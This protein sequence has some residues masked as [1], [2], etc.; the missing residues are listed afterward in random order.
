MTRL[1]FFLERNRMRIQTVLLYV[2]LIPFLRP[3][4]FDEVWGWY[5]T[6]FTLWLYGAMV[7]ILCWAVYDVFHNGLRYKACTY[8]MAAYY[9]LFVLITLI[10]QKGINEGLQK[11]FAAPALYVFC[12]LSLKTDPRKFLTAM[13]NII[14]VLFALSVTVLCPFV[15]NYL[16]NVYHVNFL[17]HVQVAA[18]YCL[19]AC[20]AAYL[21]AK[22]DPRM[23]QRC[24]VLVCLGLVQTLWAGTAAGLLAILVLVGGMLLRGHPRL[25]K[26]TLLN[27]MFFYGCYVLINACVFLFS[28][29]GLD[30]ALGINLS[31]SGRTEIWRESF[32][33]IAQH[34]FLG[35][36]AY[37]AEI[38]T[39][40]NTGMNYAHNE[41]VQRLLDGGIVLCVAYIVMLAI[42]VQSFQRLRNKRVMS[43]LNICLVGMLLV[44]LFESVTDYYF[45]AFFFVLL[46][47][48][49]EILAYRKER[50][51]GA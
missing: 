11:M 51:G 28:F 37:G 22:I 34:P 16:I 44:M 45:V 7:L 18:Q 30:M 25:R 42:F 15:T 1:L 41:F 40:F 14:T 36:G 3:R 35:Y 2:I 4:G 23:K 47:Y 5:K 8:A 31:I 27:P 33:L 10:Q 39:S 17:G 12:M 48:T 20:L 32:K 29:T 43:I 49:P 13:V 24:I 46:A 26:L 9:I 50:W 38:V 21:L 19:V 6:F